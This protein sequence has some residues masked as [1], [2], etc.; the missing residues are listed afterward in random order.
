MIVAMKKAF[1]IV[2]NKDRES[3]LKNLRK[4]GLIHIEHTR[5][6]KGREI[7][8]IQ[9]D[10]NLANQ[11][12]GILGNFTQEPVAVSTEGEKQGDL[13]FIIQHIIDLH[14]RHEQLKEYSI[15]L[16][17]RI[18]QWERWGDFEPQEVE[19]L[20]KKNIYLRFYEVLKDQIGSFPKGLIIKKISTQGSVVKCLAISWGEPEVPFKEIELPKLSLSAMQKRLK[21]DAL[22]LESIRDNLAAHAHYLEKLAAF[23]NSLEQE[24]EF[25]EAIYGTGEAEELTYLKGYVPFDSERKLIAAARKE[26]WGIL[27]KEPGENDNVPTLMR[28][29][30]WIA[31]IRPVLK[32]LEV[33]PG[34]RELDISPVFL[35]F[36]SLFFGMLIGDAG[37]GLVY[38]L[39]TALVHKKLGKKVRN[40]SI[41]FLFYV[42][43]SCAIIWGLL[44]GSFFGQEWLL[45]AGYKPLAPSLNNVSFIQA[46][47]FL[48]G[49]IHLS[50]AHSWRAILKAPALS[51]LADIGWISILWAA[52]FIAKTLLLGDAFP[53]SGKWLIIAGLVLVLFF[54]N[55]Q[56]N[57]LKAI[58]NGLGT[59]ALSLMNNFTDIVSYV[60]LF[61]VGL[62][63][64]AIADAFNAMALSVA[65]GGIVAVIMGGLILVAGHGLNIILGPMSVLV[66]G[67]RLNVLEFSGHANVT[68]SGFEYKPLSEK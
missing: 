4:L 56:K 3:T 11:A 38:L 18:D 13:K 67:V 2:Q 30:Y 61:A 22:T 6:P 62:A 68:W 12:M 53:P 65:S 49:A 10:L 28:N 64:V 34:Y 37:Y 51:A 54:T 33:V 46:F 60:R 32:L 57:L 25:Y 45:K 27:L 1:L 31:L 58:G 41:F 17:S 50:I 16:K 66:H 9:E 36:F 52:F 5:D 40:K 8:L 21:E 48:V 20:R 59:I 35:I 23:K 55:P 42:L 24:L 14:K 44:I 47:C 29:P 26:G 63:T 19:A 43:S 39:L 15:T 7:T